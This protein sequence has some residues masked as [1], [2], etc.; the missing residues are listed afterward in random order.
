MIVVVTDL[1]PPIGRPAAL[2]SGDGVWS[3]AT[4]L[5][6]VGIPAS[7]QVAITTAGNKHLFIRDLLETSPWHVRVV[8]LQGLVV[9]KRSQ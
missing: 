7:A 4:S 9:S 5:A 2:S 3:G 6:K 8:L 1:P